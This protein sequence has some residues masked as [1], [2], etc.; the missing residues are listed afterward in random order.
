MPG[1]SNKK[2]NQLKPAKFIGP[3]QPGQRRKL[4]RKPKP[5]PQQVGRKGAA[6]KGHVRSACSVT[7]PFCADAKGAKRPDG[8][9]GRSYP[10]QVRYMIPITGTAT[11]DSF[12]VIQ[13]TPLY[14]YQNAPTAASWVTPATFSAHNGTGFLIGNSGTNASEIRVVS[15]GVKFM[16]D[17]SLSNCQGQV[18]MYSLG[19][20]PVSTTYAKN[21]LNYSDVECMALT[22]GNEMTWVSKPIGNDAHKF[23]PYATLNSNTY[24]NSDWTAC[25]IETFGTNGAVVVGHAEIVINCEFV[26]GIGFL[27]TSGLGAVEPV[28]KPANPIAIHAQQ[29]AHSLMPAVV[30]GGGDALDRMV[31]KYTT[32]A[33]T[34][35]MSAGSEWMIAALA[36]L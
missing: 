12:T 8:L 6:L 17:A 35:L 2:K 13:V 34:G 1:K 29:Q 4:P 14:G 7:N 26:P 19:S 21:V 28:H 36:A 5:M 18:A 24:A 22:P 25:V 20:V 30:K 32:D 23:I 27:N 16:A 15:A 11:N 3:L 9:G 33:V 10:F 31:T